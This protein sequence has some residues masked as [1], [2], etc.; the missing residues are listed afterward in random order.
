[1]WFLTHLKSSG[2]QGATK[3]ARLCPKPSALQCPRRDQAASRGLEPEQPA[4]CFCSSLG[5]EESW[6]QTYA[7]Q[8]KCHF[9]RCAPTLL[10]WSACHG[11]RKRVHLLSSPALFCLQISE[12]LWMLLP[13]FWASPHWEQ[14]MQAAMVL[15]G[16][17]PC[18][19]ARVPHCLSLNYRY[20]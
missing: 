1:M 13:P 15:H 17:A 6:Y 8:C 12:S 14:L 4:T 11:D 9:S 18:L 16:S 10:Q 5:E 3:V 2:E 19:L 20:T 7:W